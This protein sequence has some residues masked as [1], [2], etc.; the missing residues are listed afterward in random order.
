M[1]CYRWQQ[2]AKSKYTGRTPR[3]QR[4]PNNKAGQFIKS[5]NWRSSTVAR[6]QNNI[7][8]ILRSRILALFRAIVFFKK[9]L[10]PSLYTHESV[11]W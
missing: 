3:V 11:S 4:A 5:I 8:H 7:F 2:K 10:G 1:R 9:N 6:D